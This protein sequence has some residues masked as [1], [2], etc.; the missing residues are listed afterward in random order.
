MHWYFLVAP[1]VSLFIMCWGIITC[2]IYAEKINEYDH[3]EPRDTLGQAV[4]IGLLLACLGP[5]GV[6]MIFCFTGFFKHGLDLPDA[7]LW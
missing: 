5:L 7:G 3:T 4:I 2:A 1:I 6:F